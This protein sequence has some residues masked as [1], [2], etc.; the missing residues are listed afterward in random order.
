MSKWYQGEGNSSDVVLYSKV[1]L[2]RNLADSPFPSRM[3]DE[4]RKSVTKRIYATLKSSK[5]ANEF[6]VINLGELS[7]AKAASYVEKQLISRKLLKN[8]SNAAFMLSK[9]ED[10]SVMLCEE[11]HIKINA[12]SSGQSLKEAYDKAN[13]LDDVFIKSFKLAY[14]DKLG[15]LT[16]SPMNIGTGMKASYVLHLPALKEDGS[17]YRISSMVSKLGLSLREMYKNAVGDIFV[18]SN[19]IS[20]GI[21]ENKAIENLASVCDQIVNQE[22]SARE[23]L[24]EDFDFEDKVYRALG[25]MKTARKLENVEF[26]NY[27]SVLRLGKA[28]NLLD[29]SYKTIG[30]LIYNLQD[31]SIIAYV[32]EEL[33]E[34]TCAKARAEVVRKKLN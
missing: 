3:S 13:E 24:K 9:S 31:A 14:S 6:D 25:I 12:F 34:T 10:I 16:A 1:R 30:D 11:D 4:I 26:L 15:F 27:L 18:L 7:K 23:N 5:L 17:I 20:L 19:Q 8:K 22:R 2:A 28:L 29:I 32:D 33:D 21:S